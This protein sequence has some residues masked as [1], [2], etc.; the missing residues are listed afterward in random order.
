MTDIGTGWHA[1][2]Y[3]EAKFAVYSYIPTSMNVEELP[4]VAPEESNDCSEVTPAPP[5]N[6]NVL[7]PSL[8]L[9]C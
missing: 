7:G 2:Q 3:G 9:A 5:L 8:A 1:V 4:T 6:L